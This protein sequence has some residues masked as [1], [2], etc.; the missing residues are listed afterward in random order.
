M[1]LHRSAA[2][3]DALEAE[4]GLQ[5]CA[6]RLGLDLNSLRRI[7]EQRAL[8]TVIGMTRGF[9]ALEPLRDGHG[10]EVD[11]DEREQELLLAARVAHLDGMTLGWRAAQEAQSNATTGHP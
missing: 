10:I 7:G 11:L 1:D 9:E 5:E 6:H 8:R 2:D 4:Y 3:L